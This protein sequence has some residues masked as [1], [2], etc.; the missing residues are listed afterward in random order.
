V[1]RNLIFGSTVLIG[2]TGSGKQSLAR[3][4][5]FIS[6][7]DILEGFPSQEALTTAITEQI[8]TCIQNRK[9]EGCEKMLLLP[10][11]V[12]RE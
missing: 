8:H 11:G 7:R 2:L 12:L 4:A 6:N 3:L 5:A 1:L 9:G 10:E